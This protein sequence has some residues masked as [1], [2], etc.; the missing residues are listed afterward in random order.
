MLYGIA[1]CKPLLLLLFY[2]Y[3]FIFYLEIYQNMGQKLGSN[4]YLI[5]LAPIKF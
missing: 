1:T 3:L 4:N 2:F 5:K